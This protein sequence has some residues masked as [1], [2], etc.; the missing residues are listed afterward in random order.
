MSRMDRYNEDNRPKRSEKNQDLYQD[1]TRNPRYTNIAEIANLNAYEIGANDNSIKSRESYQQ[2][3]KYRGEENYPKVK[4]DL[5]D[6]K[7]L[8]QTKEKKSYDINT[9]LEEARKNRLEKDDLEE[10]R[11]LKYT[12]Y[13]ILAGV[14]LEELLKYREEKK[15]RAVTPEEEGIREFV[16]TIASKTLA[17][18]I[19]KETTVDLLSDLM[20]TNM[21]DKVAPQEQLDDNSGTIE[22]LELTLGATLDDVYNRNQEKD[23]N[24]EKDSE[25][26]DSE[27]ESDSQEDISASV[28]NIDDESYSNTNQNKIDNSF[29]TKSMDLSEE[30]FEM[31]SDFK[32]KGLPLPV[33]ILIALL[34]IIVVAVAAYFIYMKI[35]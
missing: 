10:K 8:Y 23:E 22:K 6:F 28:T 9:V 2:M 25:Q 5:D 27:N 18:E 34:I 12:S 7:F 21:L 13:N 1:V 31:A 17:G 15:K 26:D 32:D 24:D 3:K 33:K 16:D 4:K 35:K 19:D 30:D 29:Y 11:K 20:A 14:N